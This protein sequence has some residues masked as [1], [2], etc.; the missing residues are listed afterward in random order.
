MLLE[1]NLLLTN[2]IASTV[3]CKN[4]I[5]YINNQTFFSRHPTRCIQEL[6]IHSYWQGHCVI[7]YK[8][9]LF[10]HRFSF[11]K[12]ELSSAEDQ[13]RLPNNFPIIIP[14]SRPLLLVDGA[15]YK[16]TSKLV[17]FLAMSTC[18]HVMLLLAYV[19]VRRTWTCSISFRVDRC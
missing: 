6:Q 13:L 4:I 7:S 11:V 9:F 10:T 14:P 19:S 18:T 3:W 12:S 16:Q 1:S 15:P 17:V 5:R 8:A 2:R